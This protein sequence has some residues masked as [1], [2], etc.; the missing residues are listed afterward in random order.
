MEESEKWDAPAALG[1]FSSAVESGL[2][3]ASSAL[4]AAASAVGVSILYATAPHREGVVPQV[5]QPAFSGSERMKGIFS[6][7][8]GLTEKTTE[9]ASKE[10]EERMK[11]PVARCCVYCD[12]DFWTQVRTEPRACL[13]L[14]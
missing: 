8:N 5:S 10:Y 4:G 6:F 12:F 7:T 1:A 3:A 9:E 11:V 14:C 2:G 13:E